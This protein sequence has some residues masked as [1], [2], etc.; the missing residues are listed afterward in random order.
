M[1]VKDIMRHM[2]QLAPLFIA[3]SW[4]NVGLL[5][6]DPNQVVTGVLVTLDVNDA[7]VDEAITKGANL[8]VSH[9]PILFSAVKKLV[10]DD[11]QQAL[12]RKIIKHDINIY[13]AHTNL[14]NAHGG[15]NDWLAESLGLENIEIMG[16]SGEY[17]GKT[18]G[19]GRVGDLPESLTFDA[20]IEQVKS[21]FLTTG[22]RYAG[23]PFDVVKRVAIIGG[24]AQGYYQQAIDVQADVYITGDVTYHV[25]QD[26]IYRNLHVI[27]PGHYIESICIQKLM[28]YLSPLLNDNKVDLFGSQ[29][30]TD[31]LVFHN[32]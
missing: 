19:M 1:I 26:M 6:G 7:V 20:L 9:H 3:E 27:D 13:A 17:D 8:I 29:L 4:D 21:S 31:A 14:D 32:A 24:A 23:N 25:A 16:V 12:Y 22:V 5:I 18:Y 11:V 2:E 15:M 10:E 28:A 30:L